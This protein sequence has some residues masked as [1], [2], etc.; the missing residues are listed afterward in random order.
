MQHPLLE[1]ADFIRQVER[2]SHFE[3]SWPVARFERLKPLLNSDQGDVQ[4][5]LKFGDRAGIAFLRG[6]V[7]AEL[8]LVCQRCLQPMQQAVSGRFLFGLISREAEMDALPD[9]MEPLLVTDAEQ[10]LLDIVED[11][12][13]LLLPQVSAHAEACSEYLLQ[14]DK[15]RQADKVASSPFAVLKNLMSDK[16]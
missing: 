10:S 9:D 7:S 14:Q 3:G 6:H 13:L 5:D 8:D 16:T 4:V 1:T 11:E 12:L 15:R 2:N